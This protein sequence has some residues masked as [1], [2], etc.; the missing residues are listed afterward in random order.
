M[1][2]SKQPM[3]IIRSWDEVPALSNEAEEAAFWAT[4]EL[5][6]ELLAQMAPQ[7]DPKLPPSRPRTKPIAR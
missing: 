3:T 5:S 7:S 1:A 4:N 6:D 2:K